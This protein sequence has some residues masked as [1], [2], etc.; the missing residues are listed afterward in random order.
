MNED[1][2]CHTRVCRRFGD[3]MHATPRDDAPPRDPVLPAG[4]KRRRLERGAYNEKHQ[5]QQNW[6]AMASGTLLAEGGV[7]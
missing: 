7:A 1:H 3:P 6:A 5:Q 4:T 2:R